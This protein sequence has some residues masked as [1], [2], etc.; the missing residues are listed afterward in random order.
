MHL[1]GPMNVTQLAVYQLPSE[2]H[3]LHKRNIIPFYNRRRGL[4]QR[5]NTHKMDGATASAS[6]SKANWFPFFNKRCE[7]TSSCTQLTVTST[8]TVTDCT[9]SV[10]VPMSN[11][12][13]VGPPLPCLHTP[14]PLPSS[15]NTPPVETRCGC[16]KT[17]TA[18]GAH[19]SQPTL[20]SA[21]P[22]A[23]A[24][25]TDTVLKRDEVHVVDD[26]PDWSRVAYYV[27]T[28]PAQATGLSFLANLGDPQKSGTFD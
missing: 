23:P 1:R 3:S 12:T 20:M 26:T 9:T 27:S 4:K 13:Y 24:A 11:I 7:T 10:T 25:Y 2:M 5:E 28:A 22:T 17:P 18:T 16:D 8:V 21:V 19:Q 14:E 15:V 6:I